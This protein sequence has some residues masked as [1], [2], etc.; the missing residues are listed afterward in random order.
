M[1]IDLSPIGGSRYQ[2]MYDDATN[3]D[4]AAG[5][6][7]YSF[8]Y[9]VDPGVGGGEYALGVSFAYR[10]AQEAGKGAPVKVIAPS[11]GI[12]WEVEAFA[13]V[14]NTKNL[15]AA[16]ELADWSVSKTANEIYAEN[17]AVVG[18]PG[19]AKPVPHFPENV[20]KLM[21]KND[22]AWAAGNREK[23]LKEWSKRYDSKSE[24]KG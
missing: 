5:D 22:F 17:Y 18:M 11:E 9:I 15:D 24:P 20:Q 10:G 3:G 12:G 6:G 8:R 16:K 23:I 2:F 19:I 13:I 14:K 7:V 21:I 1:L 4:A